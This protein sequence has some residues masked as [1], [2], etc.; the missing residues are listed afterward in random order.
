M[1]FKGKV[2]FIDAS[3]AAVI[4]SKNQTSWQWYINPGFYQNII[5]IRRAAVLE[6]GDGNNVGDD[7]NA[8]GVIAQNGR[9]LLL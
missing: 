4:S 9:S 8:Y 5:Y 3:N 1:R 7:N 6:E 2:S